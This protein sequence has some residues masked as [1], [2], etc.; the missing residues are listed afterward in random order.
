MFELFR[1]EGYLKP[2]DPAE[3]FPDNTLKT[4]LYLGMLEWS[5]KRSL[6]SQSLPER[7]GLNSEPI[8]RA[9]R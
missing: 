5:H 9:T 7:T 1:H 2:C 4:K 6:G 8:F 3:P